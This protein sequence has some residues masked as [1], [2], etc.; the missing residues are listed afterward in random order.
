MRTFIVLVLALAL[1]ALFALFPDI[2]ERTMSIHAFGWLFEGKQGPFILLLLLA[3]A[4]F[5]LLRRM[6]LAI[7]AGP[8][9]LWHVLRSGS[10]KRK[11]S[12]LRDGLAA[13]LDMR[14]EQ[15]WKSFRKARGFLPAWGD[16]LLAVLPQSPG[17][18]PLPKDNDDALHIALCARIAT[19][20]NARPKPD[21]G[22]RKAHLAAWLNAHPGAPLALE[23]QV[24]L[25]EEEE[26][27]QALVGILENIWNR[28]GSSA[29]RTAPRLASAYMHLAA[30]DADSTRALEQ[31][32]KAHRLQAE[33]NAITLALGRALIDADDTPACRKLWML[34]LEQ[35]NNAQVAVELVG[36]L[37]DD[38]LKIYRK[39][40]KK[41]AEK[42]TPA[43]ALLRAG[44]AHAAG[45]SGLAREHMDKLLDKHPS[46]QAWQ[47]LGKW[48]AEN[49]EWQAAAESYRQAL[50]C[51][52]TS[53]STATTH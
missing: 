49:N 23:R 31:L 32:R 28:G 4:V 41:N 30:T 38:A 8:G 24:D 37:H 34:H 40:E 19:D 45:L 12:Y 52:S 43:L 46:P 2:A 17:D 27:W 42:I 13:W 36:L 22:V 50:A 5:W 35:Q 21:I 11:E 1:A 51:I 44:L 18:L 10:K 3:L 6:L 29:A 47:M 16:D 25:L 39:L 20:P 9:Q 48:Q 15:G 26:N 33:N 7:L 14:G 53:T